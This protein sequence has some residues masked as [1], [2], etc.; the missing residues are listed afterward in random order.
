MSEFLMVLSTADL[1]L[2]GVYTLFIF[3][4]TNCSIPH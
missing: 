3:T 2:P 1:E 4:A